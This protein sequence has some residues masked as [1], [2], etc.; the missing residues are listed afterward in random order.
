MQEKVITH[1]GTVTA[2]DN[3][4]I[5]VTIESESACV[6]CH[7]KGACSMSDKKDKII[8]VDVKTYPEVKVGDTVNV[9]ITKDSGVFAVIIS[10]II[11]IILMIL[12]LFIFNKLD[13][14]EPMSV[15]YMFVLLTVYF[16]TIYLC[17]NKIKNKINI[18]IKI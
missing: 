3:G 14:N 8:N 15:L 7:A 17:R 5:F 9:L 2:I 1:K 13:V 11:P 16:T 18:Q 4:E 6:S 10:Y 12:S